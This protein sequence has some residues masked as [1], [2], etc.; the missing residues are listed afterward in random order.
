M[1]KEEASLER[2]LRREQLRL[3]LN[4]YTARTVPALNIDGY[5]DKVH[6]ANRNAGL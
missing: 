5:A 4:S 2:A 6:Q 1:A 3:A